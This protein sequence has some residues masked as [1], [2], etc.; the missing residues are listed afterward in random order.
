MKYKTVFLILL[1][2]SPVAWCHKASNSFLDLTVE[3]KNISG[4]WDISLT[5]LEYALGLDIDDNG[6]I[7]WRELR[8]SIQ[9]IEAYAFAR[10][11]INSGADECYRD[12]EPLQVDYHTDG[13]YAVLNF[14]LICSSLINQ[15]EAKYQLFFDL[16]PTHRGLLW[17]TKNDNMEFVVFSPD[18]QQT[19]FTFTKSNHWQIFRQF[20][21]EGVW[22]IW[23]G[24]DHLLFLICLLL[25]SVVRKT[26]S[27]WVENENFSDTTW[28]IGKIVTAFTFAHSI[29]LALAVLQW[30]SLPSR[31]VESAIALSVI[32]VA[33]NNIHPFFHERA[34]FV[35]LAFGLIH[36]FGF[37]SV[38]NGLGL[39]KDAIGV[40][41]MGFNFGVEIGQLTIV[42][43]FLPIAY[44]LRSCWFYQ[45]IILQAG[46]SV[47]AMLATI[48]FLQRTLGLS[49]FE[50]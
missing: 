21:T 3:K 35:A 38:L 16:D 39:T 43:I 37:A 28:Q 44:F 46:S 4:R 24:Y 34:W 2:I 23:T 15:L 10:L 13:A 42:S 40:S 18:R 9:N 41:L 30:V 8:R 7:T 48:W 29:T 25:P 49:F 22:H 36:G 5:D 17:I 45:R 27:G 33:I 11:Q 19:N 26:S 50:I 32:L 31:L 12:M 20:I 6:E 1:L 14:T 47:I